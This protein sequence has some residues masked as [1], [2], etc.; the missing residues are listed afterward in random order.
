MNGNNKYQMQ[1][2]GYLWEK[3]VGNVSEEGHTVNLNSWLASF[4]ELGKGYMAL[5]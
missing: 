5:I 1:D 2:S 4:L 3:G